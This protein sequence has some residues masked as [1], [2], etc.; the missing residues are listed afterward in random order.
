MKGYK[1]FEVSRTK[2]LWPLRRIFLSDNEMRRVLLAYAGE[3]RLI[4]KSKTV[5]KRF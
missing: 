3:N 5:E 2:L 4:F 1:K